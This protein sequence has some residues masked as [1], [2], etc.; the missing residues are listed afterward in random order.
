L[1]RFERFG[2]GTDE[3]QSTA[4]AEEV[5]ASSKTVAALKAAL[6]MYFLLQT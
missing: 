1:T 2:N 5:E 3:E 6:A 4:S